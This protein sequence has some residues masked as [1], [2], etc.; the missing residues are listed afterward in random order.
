MGEIEVGKKVQKE[1][2]LKYL[3][4]IRLFFNIYIYVKF[5]ITWKCSK[6][7]EALGRN[8]VKEIQTLH[9][10]LGLKR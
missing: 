6:F 9:G 1:K 5:P 8:I 7:G 4:K 2:K 10:R 3:L